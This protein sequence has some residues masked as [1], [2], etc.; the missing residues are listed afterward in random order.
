MTPSG[1]SPSRWHST[2]PCSPARRPPPRCPR[3]QLPSVRPPQ[4]LTPLVVAQR[5]RELAVADIDRC[6]ARRPPL[7]EAVGETPR[8]L[9]GVEALPS[10]RIGR[11]PVER[12]RGLLPPP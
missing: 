9:A 11:E 2:A 10:R 1:T 7:Q 4:P 8:G 3:P 5:P 12:G 6:H